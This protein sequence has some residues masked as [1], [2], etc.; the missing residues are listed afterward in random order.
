MQ[1]SII[2]KQL[3]LG[4]NATL[5][6]LIWCSM[7]ATNGNSYI[8]QLVE[9]STA[10]SRRGDGSSSKFWILHIPILPIFQGRGRES[11]IIWISHAQSIKANSLS[12]MYKISVARPIHRLKYVSNLQLPSF[13]GFSLFWDDVIGVSREPSFIHY[14]S[15][16][17]PYFLTFLLIAQI[18]PSGKDEEG[19]GILSQY[20]APMITPLGKCQEAKAA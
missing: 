15:P 1:P 18:W 3:S 12:W 4:C 10:S 13:W 19:E 2:M 6:R 14:I 17:P 9:S 7:E 16:I 11:W 20:K 5:A 8:S